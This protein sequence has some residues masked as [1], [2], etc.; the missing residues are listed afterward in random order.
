M[1]CPAEVVIGDNLTFSFCTHD[2]DTG[3]LTDADSLPVYRI[4]EEGSDTAILAG[5]VPKLDDSNTIG[6]YAKTIDCSQVNGFDAW[7]SYTIL[8]GATVAGVSGGVTF[9]FRVNP[10]RLTVT[11]I[12]QHL[13]DS[14]QVR[15]LVARFAAVMLGKST[16]NGYTFRSVSDTRD[17][18][19]AVADANNNRT[20]MSYDDSGA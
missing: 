15:A 14:V 20:S 5:T 12:W 2:P 8:V 16:N 17:A 1:G 3:R 9:G 11:L 18:V 10:E 7:K 13:V 19:S 4:Y 6:S